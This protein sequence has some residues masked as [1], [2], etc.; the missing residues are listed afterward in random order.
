MLHTLLLLLHAH[1]CQPHGGVI[2]ALYSQRGIDKLL[3]LFLVPY[4]TGQGHRSKKVYHKVKCFR[5]T[6]FRFYGHKLSSFDSIDV[7][8]FNL[9]L[10]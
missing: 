4:F 8:V 10:R 5:T 2:V 7:I 9:N 1:K 3:P 6:E